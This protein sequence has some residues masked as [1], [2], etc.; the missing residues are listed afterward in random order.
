MG[1]SLSPFAALLVA[2]ISAPAFAAAPAP[3]PV[4]P[5]LIAAA[6]TEGKGV[7]YT[8]IDLKVAEGLAKTFERAYPGVAVQ[9]ERIGSER[10]FQR[11]QQERASNIYSA[12][13]LDGSDQAMF[14]TFKRQGIL[15]AFVPADVAAK[16]PADQR[17]PDG[18]YASVRFTLMPISYNKNLVKPEEAPKSF[19]DLL[20]PKWTGKMV[21]AHPGYSG[22]IVTSTFQI[23]RD[24]GWEYFRKL[25]KQKVMQVQSATEPPKK[26]A[27]G[28]RAVAADGLEYVSNLEK[29]KGSPIEI[30]YPSEGTPFVPGCAAMVK[31]APHPSAAKL[32]MSFLFSQP[33]QQFLADAGGMRSFHPDVMLKAGRTPLAQIKLMKSDPDAQ[34]KATDTLKMKYTEYFGI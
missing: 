31:N 26:L 20:D 12:D 29:E 4:T 1:S 18:Q 9:I 7:F 19:A 32:F 17:D 33:A 22:G 5:Q 25:A 28:E 10:M 13:V 14:V 6:K 21:K 24:L 27:L 16:W 2:V 23:S 3:T 8:A 15:E 30:V 11:L 34:E